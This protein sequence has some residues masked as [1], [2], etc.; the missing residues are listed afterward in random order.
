[1]K[2]LAFI[3]MTGIAMPLVYGAERDEV[4]ISGK[5][6][7]I[8]ETTPKVIKFN[9]C[10][11]LIKGA[12][13]AQLDQNGSFT[14]RQEMMY[15]Q[16]MTVHFLQYFIN[17]YVQP[18]DSVHLTIDAALLDQ[19]DFA[20]LTIEGDHADIS[21]QLNLCVNY[22]YQLP[23]RSNNLNLSPPDM[24]AAVK[25]D[26]QYYLQHLEKYV[27]EKHLLPTVAEW[28]KRDLRLLVS[29][30]IADYGMQKTGSWADRRARAKLFADPFFDTYNPENFQSMMFES[31][32]GN[33][34]FSLTRSDSTLTGTEK[35]AEALQK[36]VALLSGEPA[37]EVRDYMLYLACLPYI[38]KHP[39][40]LDS[41][42]DI[43]PLFTKTI[44]YS[45]LKKVSED[46]ASPVFPETL[47]TGITYLNP[48]GET[49]PV[50]E[51]D[52]LR[53][54]KD[55]Y[56]D[57]VI[58]IDVYATWCGP[59][60]E[61]MRYA[62]ALHEEMKGKDVVFVN[63]CLQ[64]AVSN[65]MELVRKR[66]I[67]GENYFFTD[68]A[69]KLFMGTYRLSGYPSYMLMDRQGRLVTTTAPRPSEA[70][71]VKETLLKL[72]DE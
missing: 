52:V 29:N 43:S 63:L 16:N 48:E 70:K 55:R 42:P 9:F 49:R 36:T 33:Y 59:C 23:M 28:A 68:D 18:G 13:S 40:V 30:S 12:Q 54:L 67:G 5:V 71:A 56:P 46:V 45:A 7:N 25:Q 31:H 37:G 39:G 50:P 17:L 47:I 66:S 65:W 41:I 21:T 34:I 44:F 11:P 4:V 53:Y 57:K 69:T 72:L 58:Y 3:V 62:P 27:K 19:S 60:L 14:V 51:T 8:T 22:L 61:E 6:I 26:Y 2:K 24:L 20:W 38:K 15:T 32:V 10:N 35:P 64:S 1:M